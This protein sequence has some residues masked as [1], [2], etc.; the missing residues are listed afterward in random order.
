MFEQ[1][2]FVLSDTTGGSAGGFTNISG[3]AG[4]QTITI[5]GLTSA[6][7]TGRNFN[8]PLALSAGFGFVS[9]GDVTGGF[10]DL[11]MQVD[12]FQVSVNTITAVPE[13]SSLLSC[14]ALAVCG[15][16]RRFYAVGKKRVKC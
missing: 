13:P 16:L 10:D 12:N 8:G 3:Q 5:S 6:D 7:F 11:A 4:W 9:R 1:V 15:L 14:T 2:F